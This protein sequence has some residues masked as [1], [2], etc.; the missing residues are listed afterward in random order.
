M[1][2]GLFIAEYIVLSVDLPCSQR[3]DFYVLDKTCHEPLN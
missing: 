1:K 3:I 2:V